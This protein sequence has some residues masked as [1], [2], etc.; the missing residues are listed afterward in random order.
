MM[1]LLKVD[2]FWLTYF[3]I[4]LFY[5][6]FTVLVYA[7]LTPLGDTSRYMSA[8]FFFTWEIFYRSTFLLDFLGGILGRIGG[9]S[10]V[11]SNLPFTIISFYIT[12]WAIE[13]LNFRKT[14]NNVILLFLISLPNFC[15][16]TSVCSK[17]VFG[18][19][20]SA[21]LGVL[22]IRF[23]N[24]DY[25]I[26]K[27]DFVAFYL[28]AMF[29]PQY[30]LVIVESLLLIY[31]LKKYCKSLSIKLLV[32]SFLVFFN[33]LCLYWARDTINQYA[34]IMFVNFDHPNASSTRNEN[35]WIEE[36]DFFKK[37]PLGMF[38]AFWG[39]SIDQMLSKPA[40][41]VTG[42][43]SV[44]ILILFLRMARRPLKRFFFKGKIDIP[45][46]PVYWIL[47]TG[48][49]FMHYPFGI[50]N[51]GSAIRYRTNFIFL[52][53]ILLL[54]MHSYYNNNQ[55]IKHSKL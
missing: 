52:F 40:H 21:I 10:N 12:K 3:L 4:R 20:F 33:I 25:N 8:G 34:D 47:F 42:L 15:I 30:L 35:I 55:Y 54:Y 19:I 13:T 28:C 53:I 18:L 2:R 27:K 17:E 37:A 23:L 29:K 44:I 49:C 43:E 16:W 24:G 22:I 9:G 1:N 36:D 41:F 48:I 31:L 11:L 45:I 6:F 5:L 51:S 39:P 46:V 38:V 26:G 14:E 7:K 32:L 50:F